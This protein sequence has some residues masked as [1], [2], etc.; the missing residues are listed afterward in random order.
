MA[1]DQTA[2][3]EPAPQVG[4]TPPPTSTGSSTGATVGGWILVGLG[5]LFVIAAIALVVIHLTQRDSNGYYTSSSLQ[6]GGPGYAVTTEGL[7]TGE[8][9]SVATDAIGRIRVNVRSNNGQPLFVGVAHRAD[10]SG[11][12]DSVRRSEVTDV[13][14]DNVTYK[15]HPGGAPAGPPG[16]QSFW[17][18][19]GTGSGQLTVTWKVKGGTWVIVLMNANAAAPVS[20]TVS[21][22][23]NT[24]LVLWVGIGCAVFGLI[25]LGAGTALLLAS[26]GPRPV[27]A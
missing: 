11:Y 5:G 15:L 23:A 7:D 20:A 13:N 9:P 19:S 6:V 10:V 22:G 26:R 3:S 18:A 12:L 1:E 14:G 27:A 21:V 25:L 16:R 8:L 17:Q 2:R 24:N 4:P